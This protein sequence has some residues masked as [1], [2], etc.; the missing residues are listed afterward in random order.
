MLIGRL[1][2]TKGSFKLCFLLF[3]LL[4]TFLKLT[5]YRII[6]VVIS[7]LRYSTRYHLSSCQFVFFH[8]TYV[9]STRI[10]ARQDVLRV[11]INS[12]IKVLHLIM[13]VTYWI[14]EASY[15]E[16]LF[17]SQSQWQ[18]KITVAP[19]ERESD[20]Q[21]Q[22]GDD[23]RAPPEHLRRQ[24][25]PASPS[26]AQKVSVHISEWRDSEREGET[27]GYSH[28]HRHKAYLKAPGKMDRTYA[29]DT[30]HRPGL[31]KSRMSWPSSFQGF[32][33]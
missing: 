6:V 19:A 8:I 12:L 3:L 14:L 21:H 2:A 30:G 25:P 9:G 10:F 15:P 24:Q 16:A 32:R 28:T 20:R 4:K 33:R 11:I 26:L 1:K 31:K 29:V 13:K 17:L 18:F 7:L 23:A 22:C 5:K 27:A